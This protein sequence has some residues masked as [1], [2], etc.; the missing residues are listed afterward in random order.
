MNKENVLVSYTVFLGKVIISYKIKQCKN[1][2]PLLS[3]LY[4][5]IFDSLEMLLGSVTVILQHKGNIK[6][7]AYLRP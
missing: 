6:R 7:E 5:D 2:I 3:F 1:R 4:L